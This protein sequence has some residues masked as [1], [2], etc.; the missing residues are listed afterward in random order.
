MEGVATGRVFPA[1]EALEGGLV[2]RVVAHD[3]LLPTARA[4]ATEIA[5]NTSAVSV[6][7]SPGR[8]CNQAIS[9][10]PYRGS[11]TPITCASTTFDS[12]GTGSML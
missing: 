8:S 9:S 5:E 12:K 6:A 10:P 11:G 2:S 3:E 4:L 1:E 7:L